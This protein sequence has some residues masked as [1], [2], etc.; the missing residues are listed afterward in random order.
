[1]KNKILLLLMFVFLIFS[2]TQAQRS[3]NQDIPHIPQLNQYYS[4]NENS[5]SYL[6]SIV[7]NDLNNWKYYDEFHFTC[8]PVQEYH[9][10]GDDFYAEDWNK[11]LG[12]Q[13]DGE[14][15]FC[16]FDKAEVL[17]VTPES[18]G[19]SYGNRV[20]LRSVNNP[21]FALLYAHLKNVS[22]QEG[23]TILAGQK[24]GEIGKS[25][26]SDIHYTHLHLVLYKNITEDIV[27]NY[28]AVGKPP[29]NDFTGNY[30]NYAADFE[31]SVKIEPIVNIVSPAN[32][33]NNI[34]PLNST[35]DWDV[36]SGA[37]KY[38]VQISTQPD[39]SPN[40]GGL[41][42]PNVENA[43]SNLYSAHKPQLQGNT[44]YYWT[45]KPT[46]NS[47]ANIG[48][49]SPIRSF[50]TGSDS[51]PDIFPS[52]LE[53]LD[54]SNQPIT[55]VKT[56]DLIK[57]RA[58]HNISPDNHPSMGSYVNYFFSTDNV[59]QPGVDT[60]IESTHH[61]ISSN[62]P[63]VE[64]YFEY[65]IPLHHNIGQHYILDFVDYQNIHS[66]SDETNNISAT[67]I[68][69]TEA[70]EFIVYKDVATIWVE[71][72]APQNELLNLYVHNLQSTQLV[73][74]TTLFG[75]HKKYPIDTSSSYPKGLFSVRLI[76]QTFGNRVK[77][78]AVYENP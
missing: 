18:D 34:D 23:Q 66:E 36:F 72:K 41:L 29:T 74:H 24:I 52:D 20:V 37:D 12:D 73:R 44:T 2:N 21:T 17:S 25:G 9:H 39:I 35:L 60:L 46:K 51:R 70:N 59:Y 1:M 47:G 61:N 75:L 42:Y 57:I 48:A 3:T 31:C 4:L 32:N 64:D 26:L 63:Y 33:A 27:N 43:Y 40:Y 50:T 11:Y 45:V 77:K 5:T 6:Y 55:N 49:F 10:C 14:P 54:L 22:V 69:I 19:H 58:K 71:F 68:N 38:H 67:P 76:G 16:G 78:I 28:L 8:E 15:V 30:T 7:G 13:D 56:G 62:T 53:I 65:R